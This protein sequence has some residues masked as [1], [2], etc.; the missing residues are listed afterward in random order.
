MRRLV[1]FLTAMMLATAGVGAEDVSVDQLLEI[2]GQKED[3]SE[4]T[5]M[6][7]WG[8]YYVYTRSDLEKMQAHNLRDVLKSTFPFGYLENRYG[9][10][11]PYALPSRAPFNSSSLRIFIDNQEIVSPHY[12]SG[13]ILYGDMDIDFVDHIEVYIGNPLFEYSTEPAFAIIKLYSKVAQ[14]DEG[15]KVG[16]RAGSYGTVATYGYTTHEMENGWSYLA[17]A[18]LEDEKRKRYEHEGASLNRDRK[19][20]HLFGSLYNE[21][22]HIL[23]DAFRQERGMFVGLSYSGTP[24]LNRQKPEYLHL[25]YD[26][27]VGDF[28]FLLTTDVHNAS[29]D[30]TD[31]YPERIKALNAYL[32]RLYEEGSLSKRVVVPYDYHNHFDSEAVTAAVKYRKRWGANRL[33]VGG[34]YRFKHFKYDRIELNGVA[35]DTSDDKRQQ[36]IS[37]LFLEDQYS[38][39]DNLIFTVGGIYSYVTN[40]RS[41]QD[42]ALH[43]WRIGLTYADARWTSKTIFNHMEESLDPFLV[44]NS[45]F[46]VDATDPMPQTRLTMFLQDL[47]Y[48]VDR[49]ELEGVYSYSWA[50]DVLLPNREGK[51]YPYSDKIKTTTLFFRGAVEYRTVDKF[52]AIG[53]YTVYDNLPVSLG[54]P[55]IDQYSLTLRSFNTVGPVDIFNEL[56]YFRRTGEGRSAYDY[57]LGAIYHYSADLTF[58]I[59]GTNL[60]DRAREGS[61]FVYR[62]DAPDTAQVPTVLEYPT[63]DRSVLFSVEYTF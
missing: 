13:I 51:L 36:R 44:G 57:S 32:E 3:L 16:V 19:T 28:S 5:K 35:L 42:D 21:N 62:L 43:G 31:R 1:G 40:S 23:L 14:K 15:S 37:T 55:R 58:S 12:G 53:A 27:K 46:L 59:K 20:A 50:T 60:L 56:L 8:V 10:P 25:G 34:E 9:F 61:Y 30:F 41:P 24:D 45:A 11:D 33:V 63:I 47:K 26:G 54:E 7:N 4:K 49:Y 38:L 29:T 17:Y 6:E 2:I 22:H 52:E 48:R 39:Q 18:S